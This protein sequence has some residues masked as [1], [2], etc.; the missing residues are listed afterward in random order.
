[1]HLCEDSEATDAR[2][3]AVFSTDFIDRALP[4]PGSALD[5]VSEAVQGAVSGVARAPAFAPLTRVLHGNEVI[6]HPAHPVVV[7]LPVGA[8]SL[9]AWY[10]VRSAATGELRHEQIA[11]AALRFGVIGALGSALTGLAQYLDTRDAARRETSVHAGLNT[12]ALGL[13]AT[14]WMLRS[15][16]RRSL[17]RRTAAGAFGVVSFS[18]WLGG[19][20]SFRHGVGVRPQALRDADEPAA[21]TDPA[22]IDTAA[23]RH[24]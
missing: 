19:D 12:V 24:S 3:D 7:A 14:S 5:R 6:G 17:A 2:E 18:G 13:Y 16:G 22:P 4:G 23:G 20:I 1:M 11:D 21:T 15:R 10:D 9:S 8:W